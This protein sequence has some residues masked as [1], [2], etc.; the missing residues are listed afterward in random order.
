M[1]RKVETWRSRR[2]M[3]RLKAQFRGSSIADATKHDNR[4]ADLAGI[5]AEIADIDI[6]IQAA[7]LC[8]SA[9]THEEKLYVDTRYQDSLSMRMTAR[10]LGV[11]VS[12]AYRL[13]R[14]VLDKCIDILSSV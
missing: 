2:D 4:Q 3:L 6:A 13:R 12:G 9:L 11:S 5:I 10:V 1:F 8:Y 14:R 7:E